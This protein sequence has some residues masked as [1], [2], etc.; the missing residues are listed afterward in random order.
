MLSSPF[1]VLWP[2]PMEQTSIPPAPA[3]SFCSLQQCAKQTQVSVL[4]TPPPFPPL[5]VSFSEKAPRILY[6]RPQ[7]LSFSKGLIFTTVF[8]KNALEHNISPAESGGLGRGQAGRTIPSGKSSGLPGFLILL[9]RCW[10]LSHALKTKWLLWPTCFSGY[11]GAPC[12]VYIN[13]V[14]TKLS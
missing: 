4:C 8:G 9:I 11:L 1:H 14:Q 12:R 2:L 13:L 7:F 5:A 10:S 3:S 6:P